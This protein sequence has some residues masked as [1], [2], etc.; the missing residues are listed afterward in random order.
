[1]LL[2]IAILFHLSLHL[3]FIYFFIINYD[4]VKN[5]KIN[6]NFILKIKILLYMYVQYY[7]EKPLIIFL[8]LRFCKENFKLCEEFVIKSYMNHFFIYFLS[9]N[10]KYILFIS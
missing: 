3:K 10:N 4:F 1:M 5:I 2:F 7:L 6:L 8:F 9:A